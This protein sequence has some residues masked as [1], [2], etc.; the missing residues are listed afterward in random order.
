TVPY[1]KK[2]CG[3]PTLLGLSVEVVVSKYSASEST[4]SRSAATHARKRSSGW[5][6]TPS[7]QSSPVKRSAAP[8]AS[9]TS[10]RATDSTRSR[11]CSCCLNCASCSRVL[12]S[13][14]SAV[15]S[16]N[17]QHQQLS[18][19]YQGRRAAPAGANYIHACRR[20]SSPGP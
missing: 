17:S 2:L 16:A 12:T 10:S 5:S 18:R 7:S 15:C 9:T 8:T 1:T 11:T 13:Q 14:F 20:D 19:L 3:G 6:S 4:G